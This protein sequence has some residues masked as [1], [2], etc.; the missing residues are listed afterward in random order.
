MAQVISTK[1]A[2]SLIQANTDAV[3]RH[4]LNLYPKSGNVLAKF[5]ESPNCGTCKSAMKELLLQDPHRAAKF[6][7]QITGGKEYQ[8]QT[9]PTMKVV[10]PSPKYIA[11]QVRDIADTEEAYK[12]LIQ[13]LQAGSLRYTGLSVRSLGDGRVRVYFY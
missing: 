12:N 10:K 3:S 4:F 7:S 9:E 13:E 6:L 2:L 8:L 1:M 11:G 5:R